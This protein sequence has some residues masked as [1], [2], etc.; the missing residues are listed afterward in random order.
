MV[1]GVR[2]NSKRALL[3]WSLVNPAYPSNQSAMVEV[4]KFNL[5]RALLKEPII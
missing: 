2:F 4:V 1:E 3:L 5:K